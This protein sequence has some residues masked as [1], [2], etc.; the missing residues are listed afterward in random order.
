MTSNAC[1]AYIIAARRT[2][3][4]RIGG[5][6]RNRRVEDLAV[7]ALQAA[8][9]DARLSPRDVQQLVLGN[10]TE[11]GNPARVIGLCAGLPETAPALTLDRQ[12]ASG[13]EAILTAIRLVQSGDADIVAAGGAE[14]LSTAPWR[15]AR[16]RSAAQQPR[17]LEPGHT[18]FEAE[19]TLA[20]RGQIARKRQDAYALAS[21]RTAAA[22]G[23]LARDIAVLRPGAAEARDE[24]VAHAPSA[25]ELAELPPLHDAGGTL[26][27]GTIS[28]SGDA[29]A[30][31]IVVGQNCYQRL[32]RPA[33]LCLVGSA[34]TGA[35]PSAEAD[36]PIRAVQKLRQRLNG[37]AGRPVAACELNETC[38]AQAIVFSDTLGIAPQT[39]NRSGGALAHG[40]PFGAS[41]AVLVVGLFGQLIGSRAA[42]GPQL[43]LAATG[44]LGGLGL[45]ALFETQAF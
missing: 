19:E 38:A 41:S 26:T 39:L 36:A 40:R 23:S 16:P 9:A 11:G 22:S 45:A 37:S 8:L 12:C 33:A 4:G 29:A 1:Q 24:W 25:E 30:M 35:P 42:S 34:A 10:A 20:V 15:V 13:L 18:D 7:A 21:R 3:I 43:G 28:P 44:A 6:H 14:S 32:G 27:S 31:V 5:L 17:F 2:V